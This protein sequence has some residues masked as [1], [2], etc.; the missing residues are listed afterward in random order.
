ME[1]ELGEGYMV[2]FP[3]ITFLGLGSVLRVGRDQCFLAGV[4]MK[5]TELPKVGI[6]LLLGCLVPG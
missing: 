3:C 1:P 2:L 5:Q 4:I 6:S